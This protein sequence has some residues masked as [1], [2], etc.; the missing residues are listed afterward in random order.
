MHKKT[1]LRW[2]IYKGDKFENLYFLKIKILYNYWQIG[3]ALF[4]QENTMKLIENTT[5]I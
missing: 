2:Y 5:Y 4:V 1:H 3:N